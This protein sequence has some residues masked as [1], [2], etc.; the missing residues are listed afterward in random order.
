MKSKREIAQER[1][2]ALKD[3]CSSL[4]QM[5]KMGMI[6]PSETKNG[7]LRQYYAMAGHKELHTFNEWKELGYHVKKG[8]SAI[9]FWGKPKAT[10]AAKEA[11]KAAGQDEEKAKEDYF[12][13]AYL[14]SNKQVQKQ[15]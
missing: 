3:L 12:P 7:L 8:E 2:A 4:E 14:F 6:E 13:L 11:A 10:T 9:L 5:V 15:A 1:R